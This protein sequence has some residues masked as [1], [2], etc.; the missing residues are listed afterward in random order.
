MELTETEAVVS[1]ITRTIGNGGVEITN[2]SS[3][4]KDEYVRPTPMSKV[5]GGAML[6]LSDS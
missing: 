3:D 4:A 1:T 5:F 2:V 6:T